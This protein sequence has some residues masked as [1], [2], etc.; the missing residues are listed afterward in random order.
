MK[1]FGRLVIASL[2]VLTSAPA[3]AQETAPDGAA[4]QAN[5]PLANFTAVNLQN[6]YIGELTSP[7]QDANQF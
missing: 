4:A 5:N 6:Y 1:K 2:A 7:D 3:A